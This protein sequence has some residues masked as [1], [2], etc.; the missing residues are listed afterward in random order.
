MFIHLYGSLGKL[1]EQVSLDSRS[2]ELAV[3]LGAPD[4]ED[5]YVLGFA[6]PI[7]D[8]SIRIVHDAAPL[9]ETFSEAARRFQTA[10]QV[11]FLGFGFGAK[12]VERLRLDRI[13]STV[14]L[15]CTT[16]AM[17]PTEVLDLVIP[18]FPNRDMKELRRIGTTDTS[19]ICLFLRERIN[20]LH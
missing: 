5:T 4:T 8:N 16:Y 17:T 7:A 20:W 2:G 18:A 1:A 19:S 12:N 9:P 11:L 6:L 3:P 13:P 10:Q 14:P 15:T